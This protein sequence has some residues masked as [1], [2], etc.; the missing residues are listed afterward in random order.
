MVEGVILSAHWAGHLRG[1][2]SRQAEASPKKGPRRHLVKYG[3]RYLFV[4]TTTWLATCG[5]L[6][7]T[8]GHRVNKGRG[9]HLVTD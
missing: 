2:Q 1:H 8:A 5:R 9:A 7:Q 3:Q 4:D 6:Q